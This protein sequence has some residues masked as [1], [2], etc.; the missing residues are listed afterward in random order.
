MAKM[1]VWFDANGSFGKQSTGQADF[2]TIQD[3]L[4]Y[5]NRFGISRSLVWNQE[6]SQD[7]ARSCN[8]RL[9]DEIEKTPGA[10]GR[11]IP[12]LAISGMMLYERNGIDY[13]YEQMKS[14]GSRALRFSSGYGRLTLCQLEP[15]VRKIRKLKPFIALKHDQASIQDILDFTEMFPDIP[16][17]ITDVIWVPCITVFDLMRRRKNIMI[18]NSWLHTQRIV[19]IVVEHFGAERLLFGTGYKSHAGAAMGALARARITDAE[20]RL[21][22]SGNLDRLTGLKTTSAK[23]PAPSASNQLW[24]RFMEGKPLDV[25]IVDAHAHLGPSGGF[26]LEFQEEKQQLALAMEIMQ[27]TGMKTMLI[28]GTTAILGAPVE[29][30]DLAE[31]VLRPHAGQFHAYLGF[32]PF[33]ANELLPRLDSYFSGPVFVGF[34]TLCDYWHIPITDKRYEPMWDYANRHCLPV[35]NHTWDGQWDSP[36]MFKDI[37]R[38]YPNVQFLLGHSGGG[39][40]GRREAEE[41][42]RENRN[43]Y[44]EFCGSFCSTILWEDTLRTVD[45]RQVLFGTDAMSHDINW[46]LARMLS[47]DVPDETLVPILG[48]NMRRILAMRRR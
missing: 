1:P 23:L 13:L 48:A 24:P 32:N 29:G 18:E 47:L 16:L 19:E 2:P 22:A 20:R 37:V 8:Q 6:I 14:T 15:V 30:N 38:R 43:V 25:D 3:R 33:Y 12:A 34:K 4:D 7:Y 35:L 21:I 28:A 27:R 36:A 40:G 39:D 11:I 42:T 41:L 9:I 46:E 31:S 10:S 44:M 45:H 5:M 17:V 26:V